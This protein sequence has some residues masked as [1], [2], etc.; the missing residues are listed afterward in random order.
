MNKKLTSVLLISP[1]SLLLFSCGGQSQQGPGMGA[2]QISTLTLAT[3]QVELNSSFPASLKGKK[4][5]EI[6]PKVGGY[7]VEQFVDEGSRVRKGQVLFQIDKVTYQ[8]AVA[9]AEATV[10]ASKASLANAELTLA[11]KK[12]LFDKGII[13][14][15]EYKVAQYTYD[16]QKAALAQ[17]N[18]Q[19]ISARNDLGFTSVTS[20][21]DGV[22]G[23]I[24]YRV[25]ALVSSAGAM[26]IT[27]VADIS[28]VFA[29][30]SINEKDLLE[31]SRK[32]D[33]VNMAEVVKDFPEVGLQLSDGSIY[34]IKGKV[35]TVSGV[36]NQ[37]TGSV[38]L[39]AKFDNKGNILRSG[40][41]ANVL[42]P[43]TDNNVILIPQ[44]MTYEIQGKHFVY[45]VQPDSTVAAKEIKILSNN[46]G[47]NYIVTSGVSAGAKIAAEGINS[48]KDGMKIIPVEKK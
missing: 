17:A 18:A 30:F 6:R 23:D 43:E 32:T 16:A 19:L 29:Y 10:A 1:L 41:S 40:A 24:N 34:P 45:A 47:Q 14:E 5:T 15:S 31:I 35:E 39:R 33:A 27:T 3:Q 25:G 38:T 22:V 13:S 48:L 12:K 36:V 21:S 42:I 37:T 2:Q 4:D 7:I 26:P 9:A 8:E 46:D 44:R 11:N 28:E 20:P